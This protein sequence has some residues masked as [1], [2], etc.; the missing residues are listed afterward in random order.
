MSA[1]IAILVDAAFSLLEAKL[2][3]DII[4]AKIREREVA[5]DSMEQITAF[6]RDL[7]DE[8]IKQ[9]EEVVK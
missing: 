9:A 6:I 8:A 1:G 3:R 5:G 2:E 4:L 7:R